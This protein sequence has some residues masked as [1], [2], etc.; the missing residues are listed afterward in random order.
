MI[1]A[2]STPRNACANVAT[3]SSKSSLRT[4]TPRAAKSASFA[5]SR[6]PATIGPAPASSNSS[7]TRRPNVPPAPVTSKAICN[8]NS[9]TL[10]RANQDAGSRHTTNLRLPAQHF[11]EDER[12]DD[13]GVG[14][15]DE[16]GRVLAEFAPGDLFVRHRAGVG[17]VAGGR[18]A[19]LAE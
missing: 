9:Y 12:G 5:G 16:L 17:P 4:V 15:D 1:S 7:I 11:G 2:R 13:G 3:S 8:H 19:D 6:V 14:L 10:R 18:I